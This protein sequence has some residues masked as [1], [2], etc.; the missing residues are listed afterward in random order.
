M[1]GRWWPW[2][3]LLLALIPALLISPPRVAENIAS[4]RENVS[5]AIFGNPNMLDP[6]LASTGSDW[7]IDSNVFEPLFRIAE[8]G[9]IVSNLVQHYSISGKQLTLEIKPLPL[10][11]GQQLTASVVAGALARPLWPSV[12][13]SQAQSLLNSVVGVRAVIAG[14]EQYLSGIAV[15]GTSTLTITLTHAIGRGFL[16]TLANPVLSIVPV[17][18]QVRGGSDWQFLNLYGT[19]GY[20]LS[21]WQPGGELT[22]L[23]THGP[24]PGTVALVVYK[25]FKK[26]V[27]SFRNGA[28]SA[29]PVNPAQL[30]QV[31]GSLL[32]QVRAL[33][34]PGNLFLVYRS[35]APRVSVYPLLSPRRWVT[36]SFRGRVPALAGGWPGHMP[37]GKPMTVYV[38]QDLPQAVQLAQTLAKLEP[39]R[40]TVQEVN[41]STLT[42]L[43]KNNQ[44]AAYIGQAD[45]FKSGTMMPLAPIR[46][47]WLASPVFA[48][49]GVYANGALKWHSLTVNK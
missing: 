47:L 22:F 18:D 28:I 46:S 20:Q 19:G 24:G 32:K 33:P 25:S 36:T 37:M 16:R 10:D 1:R 27:L 39:K 40:V 14:K 45:L 17:A 43:A 2:L 15:T 11:N 4:P 21:T 49:M 48:R 30:T 6:A 7:T 34:M 41:L 13:S 44:I 38:N 26:A 31:P 3:L 29:L 5:V 42:S 9:G 12:G 35:H 23:K 8:Y